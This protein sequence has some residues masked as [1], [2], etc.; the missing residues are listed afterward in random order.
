MTVAPR[1]TLAA[2]VLNELATARQAEG[3]IR[4][5]TSGATLATK[6][7]VTRSAIWKA[8]TQLRELGTQ[9][10]AIPR[11]GYRLALPSSPL[12]VAQISSLLHQ[13]VLKQLRRGE[14]VGETAS[15][16]ATLLARDAPPPGRFDFLTAEYQSAGRGRRGRSWLAAPGGAICL[17]WMWSFEAMAAQMGALSLAIGVGVLRALKDCGIEGIELKWP[18]DLVAGGGKLGGILVEIRSESAGP[19]QVVVGLGL[20]VS[21]GK[22]LR[23]RIDATGNHAVDLCTLGG[24]PERNRLV[25][26]VLNHGIAVLEDFARA[27]LQPFLGEYRAADALQD[28]PIT[29]HNG[30]GN[31][32]TGI[33]RGI[34]DGGAL[35]VE[36]SGK[37]HH[38]IAGEVSIRPGNP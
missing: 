19:V 25:A 9:I 12:D 28:R 38:I 15:T 20:N 29:L 11:Q 22:S 16:N 4:H 8:V 33:A 14:C 37:I 30:D 1:M 34:D 24:A 7:Q 27:G 23:E 2:R 10:E 36:H 35:R 18:N 32:R 26:A 6:M 31:A 3:R 13:A 5:F 21:M 17:S